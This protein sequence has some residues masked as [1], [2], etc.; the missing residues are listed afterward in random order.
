MV[1]IL[2]RATSCEWKLAAADLL[3]VL[4]P[5]LRAH[6]VQ[7]PRLHLDDTA[8]PLPENG[9]RS[10]RTERLWGHLSARQ[11]EESGVWVDHLPAVVLEFAG[12]RSG[13]HQ[14]R[15]LPKYKGYLQA[16]AC[17]GNQAHYEPG[18]I[19]EVGCWA[20]CRRRFF[21]IA[22]AQGN[23]VSSQRPPDVGDTGVDSAMAQYAN[24]V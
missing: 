16:D 17:S 13:S 18:D 24:Q 10:T 3:E 1:S 2:P 15:Y 23:P 20:H 5:P 22:K 14:L 21:E 11:R 8:L 4:L 7:A 6:Q 19:V 12:S 9:L